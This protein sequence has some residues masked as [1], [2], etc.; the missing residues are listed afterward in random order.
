MRKLPHIPDELPL[1][2]RIRLARVAR[3]FSQLELAQAAGMT[4]IRISK[5]E[6]GWAKPRPDEVERLI[7]ALEG[8]A[9]G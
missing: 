2:D 9:H 7:H 5:I 6:R 8:A 4:P 1:P 3:G